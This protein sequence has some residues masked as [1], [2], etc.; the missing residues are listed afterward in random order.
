MLLI[1]IYYSLYFVFSFVWE[2]FLI[3]PLINRPLFL[4]LGDSD[5][6]ENFPYPVEDNFTLF[7]KSQ[8]ISES[9]LLLGI[10]SG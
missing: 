1:F 2:I 9:I 10:E 6:M 5:S 4:F 7:T 3:F 8:S